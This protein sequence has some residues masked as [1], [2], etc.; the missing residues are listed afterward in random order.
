VLG[1]R[2]LDYYIEINSNLSRENQSLTKM[3]AINVAYIEQ[4]ESNLSH[5]KQ[6]NEALSEELN[7]GLR[8]K[9][10]WRNA[11]LLIS[12]ANVLILTSIFLSR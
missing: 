12:G 2:S 3:N 10:K 6:V 4:L 9:K 11:T 7:E 8:A 1:V 5:L